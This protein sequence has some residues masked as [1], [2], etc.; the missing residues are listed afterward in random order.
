[1]LSKGTALSPPV[2]FALLVALALLSPFAL[3][4]CNWARFL[5]RL[6]KWGDASSSAFVSSRWMHP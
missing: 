6:V 1:V 5:R 3:R 2:F 4:R